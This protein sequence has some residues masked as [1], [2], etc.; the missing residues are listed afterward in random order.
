MTGMQKDHKDWKDVMGLPVVTDFVDVRPKQVVKYLN[1]YTL[2]LST[3][4]LNASHAEETRAVSSAPQVHVQINRLHRSVLKAPMD[5]LVEPAA[6]GF[7]AR[8]PDLPSAGHGKDRIEA[9]DRLKDE[10]ES[11]FEELQ[12][13]DDVSGE[14]LSIKK[15]LSERIAGADE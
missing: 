6:E 4:D 8:V 3:A 7:V 2:V 1:D 11:L 9:I 10:I 5:V 12:Q 14:R 13:S 15:F